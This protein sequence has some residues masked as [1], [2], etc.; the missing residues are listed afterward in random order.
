MNREEKISLTLIL[1]VALFMITF[2]FWRKE[3]PTMKKK[4]VPT[5]ETYIDEEFTY[6]EMERV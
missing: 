6:I 4:Y 1:L 3:K 2:I 5:R